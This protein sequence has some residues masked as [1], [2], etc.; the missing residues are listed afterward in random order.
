MRNGTLSNISALAR[1]FVVI[2][3]LVF[4]S[5]AARGQ[6]GAALFKTNCTPCHGDDGAGNTPT[7]KSLK[8]AD[9]RS[10]E[11][12]KKTDAELATV[13]ANGKGNMPEWKPSL[14]DDQIKSLVA[15]IRKLKKKQSRG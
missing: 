2:P 1:G 13:I 9:L 12:Q 4:W 11:I 8:A 14:S 5:T 15:Y 3:A 6:D 7:G 10:P